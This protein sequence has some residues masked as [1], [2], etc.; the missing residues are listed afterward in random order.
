MA[1]GAGGL[2]SEE[3]LQPAPGD[4]CSEVES[5]VAL[6]SHDEVEMVR[7][8]TEVLGIDHV[9]GWMHTRIPSLGNKTP[10]AL[11]RTASGRQQIERVLLKIEHGVY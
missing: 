11:I 5:D 4:M 10:Y 9:G 1:V 7:R 3:S 2:T 6:H 8:A